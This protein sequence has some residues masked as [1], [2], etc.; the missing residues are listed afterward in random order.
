MKRIMFGVLVCFWAALAGCSSSSTTASS[1]G[2][3]G[4][5]SDK[6]VG[7]WDLVKGSDDLPPGT[8]V[9]FAGDGKLTFTFGIN[10]NAGTVTMPGS[11]KH[12]GDKLTITVKSPEGKDDTQTETIKTLTDTQL[13]TIDKKNRESEFKR[14]K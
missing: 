12:E 7:K 5:S 3:Q 9:E 10:N 1:G 11:Y 6:L 2:N 4:A 13:V 14:H 8:V